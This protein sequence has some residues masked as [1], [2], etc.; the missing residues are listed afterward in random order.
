MADDV[1]QTTKQTDARVMATG[2]GV[3]S[4]CLC[5]GL[6]LGREAMQCDSSAAAI[7][8]A[9][10]PIIRTLEVL[11]GLF[12]DPEAVHAWLRTPHPDLD[13]ST[14]LETILNNQAQ[15]VCTIL[16]NALSGVPV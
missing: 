8:L 9:L 15:A 6:G 13:G 1:T 10:G 4:E 11:D 2:L 3:S 12:R 7:Q 14:A 5:D 16:E